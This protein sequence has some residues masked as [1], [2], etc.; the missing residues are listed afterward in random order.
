MS[1]LFALALT[2]NELRSHPRFGIFTGGINLR[3][4]GL[5][6]EHEHLGKFLRKKSGPA[7]KVGLE[8]SDEPAL[9]NHSPRS[10]QRRSH[11]GWVVGKVVI[12]L[13]PTPL[14]VKLKPSHSA[15]K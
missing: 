7:K 12:D 3:Y 13:H 2:R 15:A 10:L 8:H 1:V 11:L 6:G 5:I 9:T 14:S 4:N